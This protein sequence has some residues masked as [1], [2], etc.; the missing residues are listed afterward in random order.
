MFLPMHKLV[1]D[2]IEARDADAAR[3][4]MER[5]LSE[6]LEFMSRRLKAGG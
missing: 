3:H 5:L 6:T 2:G 4:A 1:L